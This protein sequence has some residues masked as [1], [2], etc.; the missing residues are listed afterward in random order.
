[1]MFS[2]KLKLLR[3]ENDLT[4]EELADK[5]NVSRQA[6]TKWECGEGIPDIVNLKQISLLF[7]ISIDEL[8]K[9]DMHINVEKINS[10]SL[11]EEIDINHIKHFDIVIG[12]I[13]ELSIKPNLEEK[14]KIELLSDDEII[15]DNY[16]IKIDDLYNRMD[17]NIKR[18]NSVNDKSLYINLFIP[19]KYLDD[20]E[21]KGK[22]N[23]LNLNDL[24]FEKIE[25]DGE[26]KYLN[27]T[28][29]KGNIILNTSK[30]DIEACYDELNG[31]LEINTINSVS[32]VTLPKDS[33]YKTVLK[34]IKNS[35]VD[36]KNCD[37]SENI[38][39]LNGVNS[40]II[41]IE[42]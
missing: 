21:L 37:D 35:F 12:K 11:V 34:G 15:K 33:Q 1:M 3:K 29:T 26:L 38:I 17:I 10:N 4:Q 7:N 14:V 13:K 19:P 5:L 39:E 22:I 20:I 8:I 16:R 6:I 32:R 27:V 2:E 28:K 31:L 36:A 40:K 41:L 23:K 25:Y 30:C 18:K 42:K 9:E 24:A